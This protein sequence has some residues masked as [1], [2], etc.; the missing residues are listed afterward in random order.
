MVIL[1]D[2][3]FEQSSSLFMLLSPCFTILEASNAYLKATMTKRAD[4]VGHYLFDIFPD[5]PDD[6]EAT[7]VHN[8]KSSLEYVLKYRKSHTMDVQKY[9]VRF[10]SGE[11]VPRY[12]TPLNSPILDDKGDI[13]Y[14]LHEVDEVSGFLNLESQMKEKLNETGRIELVMYK[15]AQQIQKQADELAKGQR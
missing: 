11:F 1:Y 3:I 9:D 13:L 15:R 4:I 8:L 12:W 6:K 10:P 2:K 14:I 7:G 5:A